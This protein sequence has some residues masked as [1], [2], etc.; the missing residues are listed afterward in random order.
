MV[1]LDGQFQMT[2]I[3]RP[4]EG[5]GMETLCVAT[6]DEAASFLGLKRVEPVTPAKDGNQ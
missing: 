1:D 2:M 6:F 3:A 4:I 5:G